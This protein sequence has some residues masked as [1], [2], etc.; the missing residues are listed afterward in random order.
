[1]PIS[2]TTTDYT[3]RTVDIFISQGI[4]PMTKG[5][6]PVTYGFGRISNYITGVQKLV[7]RYLISLVNTGV[8]Q[9]LQ[10][11]S[12]NNIQAATHIFNF[13][14][15]SVISQFTDYQNSNPGAPTD[16]SLSTVQLISITSLNSTL[17]ITIKLINR[18]GDATLFVLPVP[19][20]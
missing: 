4:N 2:G 13:A 12:A 16:E 3:G 6:Q 8:M 11:A 18:A 17:N 15:Y 14:S 1:M 19:L 5:V 20:T 10:A 9:Q 7:Q